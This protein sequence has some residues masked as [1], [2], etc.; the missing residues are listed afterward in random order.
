[1]VQKEIFGKILDSGIVKENK[2][3]LTKDNPSYQSR[4]KCD[5]N[6]L[7][8]VTMSGQPLS[9]IENKAAVVQFVPIKDSPDRTAW[10]Q[11][12]RN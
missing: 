8:V 4:K 10:E 3:Q 7:R 12:I 9:Q 6:V 2:E 5:G 11:S 1:M